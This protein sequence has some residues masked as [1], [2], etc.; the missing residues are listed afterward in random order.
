[1]CDYSLHGL[2]N[3]LARDGEELV[4]HRFSTGAIGLTSPAEL[5]RAVNSTNTTEKK[6]F[7]SAIK[8]LIF[9]PV[10]PEA[11]AVCIPPGARLRI[12]DIPVS[13]QHELGIGP[14]ETVTFTQTTAMPNTYHDAVRFENGRQVLLQVLKAGQRVVVLSL[15]PEDSVDFPAERVGSEALV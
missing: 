15:G 13:L 9:P 3:R 7:W 1:M 12:M 10:W 5:C 8:A 14:D 2:P 11:P 6:S 4:A